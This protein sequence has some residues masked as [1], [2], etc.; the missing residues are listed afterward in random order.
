MLY[1]KNMLEG[2]RTIEKISSFKALLRVSLDH[3]ILINK[4]HKLHYQSF[5]N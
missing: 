3:Q 1:C 5:M 4:S 2:E